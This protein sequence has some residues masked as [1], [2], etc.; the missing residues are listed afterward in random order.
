METKVSDFS[1]EIL[2]M[3][4]TTDLSKTIIAYIGQEENKKEIISF[5]DEK[6]KN[7]DRE[8]ILEDLS[9]KLEE[10]LN[11]EEMYKEVSRLVDSIT[12]KFLDSDINDILNKFEENSSKIYGFIKKMFDKFIKSELPEIIKLFNVSKIVEDEINNFDVEFTEKLILDIA[13]K[14]LRA[15]TRLGALLGAIM[16]LLSPFLQIL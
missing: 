10:T 14:E 5:F 16:G 2:D 1:P 11:S 13:Q 15:I 8:K 12:N 7:I 9:V 3:I 4:N 6:I